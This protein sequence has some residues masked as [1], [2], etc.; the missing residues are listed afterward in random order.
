MLNGSHFDFQAIVLHEQINKSLVDVN[1]TNLTLSEKWP[2]S[3]KR[4]WNI[5]TAGAQHGEDDANIP[6]VD[7][8]LPRLVDIISKYKVRNLLNSDGG[9]LYI[10]WRPI[11]LSYSR[12]LLDKRSL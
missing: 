5:I 12:G 1:R 10:G 11:G 7:K 6:A 4:C 9:G 3:F 8:P 2:D